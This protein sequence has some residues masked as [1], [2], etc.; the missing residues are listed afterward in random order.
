M[1][2]VMEMEIIE[3][4]EREELFDMKEQYSTEL[5]INGGFHIVEDLEEYWNEEYLDNYSAK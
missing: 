4:L 3:R 2:Y 5:P 1:T